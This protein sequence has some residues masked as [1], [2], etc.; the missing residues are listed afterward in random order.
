MRSQ[1]PACIK[2]TFWSCGAVG[3]VYHLLHC[4]A[5]VTQVCAFLFMPPRNEGD[6]SEQ[7]HREAQ[8]PITPAVAFY[9]LVIF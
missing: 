3:P 2:N 4:S 6:D 1:H 5:S 9:P 7:T 8:H